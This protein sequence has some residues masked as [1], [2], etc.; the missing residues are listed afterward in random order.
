MKKLSLFF[1]FSI[2]NISTIQCSDQNVYGSIIFEF[3]EKD[4]NPDILDR[5]YTADQNAFKLKNKD[6]QTPLMFAIQKKNIGFI[7]KLLDNYPNDIVSN[8]KDNNG[9]AAIHWAFNQNLIN[10]VKKLIKQ[11]ANIDIQDK[12]GNTLLHKAFESE[13]FDLIRFLLFH[14]ARADIQNKN[15][16][17]ALHLFAQYPYQNKD[18]NLSTLINKLIL[19]YLL[20]NHGNINAQDKLGLTPLH[21]AITTNNLNI[22]ELFIEHGANTNIQDKQNDT[23]IHVAVLLHNPNKSYKKIIKKLINKINISMK[24]DYN[25]TPT[26]IVI[27][28][29]KTDLYPLFSISKPQPLMPTYLKPY[30]PTA[31]FWNIAYQNESTGSDDFIDSSLN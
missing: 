12:L 28:F 16:K 18:S 11:K 25:E 13:D 27:K 21:I 20:K 17:T 19:E 9:D 3:I 6:G 1:I 26:D 4:T 29:K 24:N 14:N 23:P 8:E 7:N 31:K 22:A 10:I 5:I 30:S 2:L 15:N